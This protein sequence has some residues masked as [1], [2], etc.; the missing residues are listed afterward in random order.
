MNYYYKI[1]K[2][3]FFFALFLISIMINTILFKGK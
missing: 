2:Y 3:G 1:D